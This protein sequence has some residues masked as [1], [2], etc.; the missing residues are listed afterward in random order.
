MDGVTNIE[1]MFYLAAA[2]NQDLNSWDTS[3]VTT[4]YMLFREASSFNGNIS[5]WNFANVTTTKWML[6]G[7]T[8]FNQNIGNWDL[9][10][11]TDMTEMFAG[12]R[13]FD[14]NLRHWFQ[15]DCSVQRSSD[16]FRDAHQ[17]LGVGSRNVVK[18]IHA[19]KGDSGPLKK[20]CEDLGLT[21]S[22]LDYDDNFP[23]DDGKWKPQDG[24]KE[25]K[26][27]QYN[28]FN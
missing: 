28:I 11:V 4:M 13:Q 12:A 26:V 19:E 7:T 10:N 24:K 15:Q 22:Q 18:K 6:Y 17:F 27:R 3:D 16:M 8:A 20:T 5:S 23:P 25:F 14:G 9:G 1:Q 2:F 21:D